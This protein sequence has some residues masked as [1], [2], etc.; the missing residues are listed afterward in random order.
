MGTT[1]NN[2]IIAIKAIEGQQKSTKNASLWQGYEE[3]LKELRN[4]LGE[5]KHGTTK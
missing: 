4:R 3:E 5:L 2:L 1:E